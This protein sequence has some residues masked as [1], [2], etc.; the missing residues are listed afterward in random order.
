[1]QSHDPR[2]W[3]FNKKHQVLQDSQIITVD[4][5]SQHTLLSL[6]LVET[7]TYLLQQNLT[8]YP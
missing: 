1:M 8:H 2:N 5:R 6:M 7:S 3:G 4:N